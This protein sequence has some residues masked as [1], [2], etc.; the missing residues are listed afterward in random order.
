MI[1][2]A[3]IPIHIFLVAYVWCGYNKVDRKDKRK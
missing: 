1:T 3:I 2:V